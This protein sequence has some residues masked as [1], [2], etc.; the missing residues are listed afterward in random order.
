MIKRPLGKTGIKVSELAFGGVEIGIPYGINVRSKS[1]MLSEAE[2]INLL[3]TSLEAG[4]NFYDTARIYGNSEN[5]IGKAFKNKRS[6]IVICTKCRHLRDEKGK[7]PGYLQ[8]KMIIEASLKESLKALKTSYIDIF[9]LHSADL[10]ILENENVLKIFSYL[11]N[12]GR[13]RATGASTYTPEETKKAIESGMWDILQVPFNLLDQRQYDFFS[14]AYSHGI[15][16]V[17]RSVLMKGILT[18]RKNNL[19]PALK[20]VEAHLTAY[21]ELLD[22]NIPDITTLATKF[23][24]SFPEVSAALIGLDRKE[25]LDKS[26]E[27]VNGE[28]LGPKK[29]LR[30]MKLSFPDPAFLNLPYWHKMNWLR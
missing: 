29:T 7:I 5:I 6:E 8:L 20:S 22:D 4:I 14:T 25:Y 19:H 28:Y 23:V 13:F 24:L 30:A 16:L 26:L 15:G 11:K 1:D 21:H 10:E 17:I 2:A 27:I 18:N 9:M 3:N 12:E